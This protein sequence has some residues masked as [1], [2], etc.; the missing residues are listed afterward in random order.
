V[1]EIEAELEAP[2][3]LVLADSYAAGWRA[4]VDGT[5][6]SIR[7]AN[8]LFR[9]VLVPAGRH[10]VRFEYRPRSV[11]AGATASLGGGALLAVLALLARRRDR[12]RVERG[13]PSPGGF[14]GGSTPA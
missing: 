3:L 1:I 12:A 6:A 8:F 2:G 5:P 11:T 10:R 4:Q 9:G 13:G 14:L 7:P